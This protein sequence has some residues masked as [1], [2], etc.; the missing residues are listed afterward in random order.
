VIG[1]NLFLVMFRNSTITDLFLF[2]FTQLIL[3]YHLKRSGTLR[4]N[5]H[6]RTIKGNINIFF[7]FNFFRKKI[8]LNHLFF[9][10]E[11]LLNLINLF[12]CK[13]ISIFIISYI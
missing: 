12:Y 8:K 7:I 11:N 10:F 6:N 4:L 1:I 9:H 13:K 2:V 3:H 5:F